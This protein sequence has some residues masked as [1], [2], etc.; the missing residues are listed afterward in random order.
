MYM[1]TLYLS[2]DTPEEHIRSHYRWLWATRWLLGIELCTSGRAVSALHPWAM[3]QPHIFLF[4]SLTC[5]FLQR[6]YFIVNFFMIVHI[7]FF[8]LHLGIIPNI[9]FWFG[10]FVCLFLFLFLFFWDRVT[11]CCL[12][13]PG[14]HFVDQA[15]LKPRNLPVSASQGWD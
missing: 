2:L 12:G 6:L 14:T 5:S 9:L 13:C 7:I 11:L 10:F 3:L 8:V 15:G 4:Q 1:S